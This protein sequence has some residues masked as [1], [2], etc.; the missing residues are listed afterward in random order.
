MVGSSPTVARRTLARVLRESRT[1]RGITSKEAAAHAGLHP[2]TLSRIERA[3]VK[4][5]PG[6][7]ALLLEHYGVSTEDRNSLLE[8]AR[9]ARQRGWWQQY[10]GAVPEWFSSYIGL[11]TEATRLRTYETEL[12]PGIVQTPDY[13]RALVAADVLAPADE[14]EA[15]KRVT[16]R[17]ERQQ[18]LTGDNPLHLSVV[19][20]DAA[21]YREIG[22]PETMVSQLEHLLAMSKLPNVQLRLLPFTAG[23]HP[24]GY[25]SF[26]ILDFP[27]IHNHT[28]VYVEYCG[29]ALYLE[30]PTELETYT[31]MFERLNDHACDVPASQ[32]LVQRALD[33]HRNR[34]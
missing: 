14:K 13:A 32:E 12:I 17:Q 18:R 5:E 25:G 11:E 16:V 15:E 33:I 3:E 19:L 22:G 8:V 10:R 26:V 30:E 1:A 24:A 29:G 2:S 6:T 20:N 31:S 27:E 34:D 4:V 23:G 7:A 21:L 9:A 28:V